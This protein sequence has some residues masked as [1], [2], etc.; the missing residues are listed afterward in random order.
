MLWQR[1]VNHGHEDQRE[2]GNQDVIDAKKIRKEN[3]HCLGVVNI[4]LGKEK[5]LKSAL[6]F[7]ERVLSRRW[8]SSWN[9]SVSPF[10]LSARISIVTSER[11]ISEEIWEQKSLF[12][13]SINEWLK[14][15]VNICEVKHNFIGIRKNRV[16]KT[17]ISWHLP[18]QKLD[19]C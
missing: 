14:K 10:H 7:K 18:K 15:V 3:G 4:S 17:T 9:A 1:W 13:S 11:L 5:T 16:R 12:N 6:L 19:I 2:L 8:P